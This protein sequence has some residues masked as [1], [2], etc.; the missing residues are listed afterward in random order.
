M[1]RT[2]LMMGMLL[3]GCR[4]DPPP[5]KL[6]GHGIAVHLMLPATHDSLWIVSRDSIP[7]NLYVFPTVR[8]WSG[9]MAMADSGTVWWHGEAWRVGS[10]TDSSWTD[11]LSR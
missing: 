5:P 2:A 3:M 7:F 10:W 1:R 4:H 9:Q 11:S 8:V 6:V